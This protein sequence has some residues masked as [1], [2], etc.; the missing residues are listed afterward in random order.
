MRSVT[1]VLLLA[2][3]AGACSRPRDGDR[4]GTGDAAHQVAPKPTETADLSGGPLVTLPQP[5]AKAAPVPTPLKPGCPA[6]APATD[7]CDG[8]RRLLRGMND[9]FLG[10]RCPK[11]E[12]GLL[13]S[14][15]EECLLYAPA[16]PKT[17]F[18]RQF[19]CDHGHVPLEER[20]A[21][22]TRRIAALD[23]C[24]DPTWRRTDAAYDAGTTSEEQMFHEWSDAVDE[25][26]CELTSGEE[27][28]EGDKPSHHAWIRLKCLR[29]RKDVVWGD[30]GAD[31]GADVAD[32]GAPDSD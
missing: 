17:W 1:T 15:Y 2:S 30:G 19:I 25:V 12:S 14:G 29:S 21:E 10:L 5:T 8:V 9:G 32:G 4:S 11:D 28:G 18:D 7:L 13:V 24:F 16:T 26:R 6:V 22:Q 31:G 20:A 3:L 27:P 23:A